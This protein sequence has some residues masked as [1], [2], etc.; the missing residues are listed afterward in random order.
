MYTVN[1]Y[2]NNY[3]IRKG[4]MGCPCSVNV[5]QNFNRKYYKYINV[6]NNFHV[7]S[8]LC[9]GKQKAARKSRKFPV[10]LI[11]HYFPN[12]ESSFQLAQLIIN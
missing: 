8:S 10:C 5:L 2:Y 6:I 7:E 11:Y 4:K 12:I 1:K 9:L 3:E